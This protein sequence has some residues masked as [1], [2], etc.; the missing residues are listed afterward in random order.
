MTE[1]KIKG[2]EV[3]LHRFFNSYNDTQFCEQRFLEFVGKKKNGFSEARFIIH[4]NCKRMVSY[5]ILTKLD[6][7][8]GLSLPMYLC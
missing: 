5:F 3:F 2:S 7:S 4:S 6:L 8:E 1:E